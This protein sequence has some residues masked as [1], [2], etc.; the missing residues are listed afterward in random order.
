MF[1]ILHHALQVE[2]L[3]EYSPV[4]KNIQYSIRLIEYWRF[5]IPEFFDGRKM[6]G[7]YHPRVKTRG[8]SCCTTS[9]LR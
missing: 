3:I 6:N 9:W 1:L 8:Y 5:L 2:N 7:I 4:V